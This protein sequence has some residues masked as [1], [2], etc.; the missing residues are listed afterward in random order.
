[1][2]TNSKTTKRRVIL[3]K[4]SRSTLGGVLGTIEAVGLYTPG[5]QLS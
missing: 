2:K 1:M 4:V 5:A 3:G